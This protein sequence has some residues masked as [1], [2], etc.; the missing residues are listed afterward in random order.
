M[1]QIRHL[2]TSRYFEILKMFELQNKNCLIN[3]IEIESLLFLCFISL[4]YF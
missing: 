3:T 1:L 4:M 2:N